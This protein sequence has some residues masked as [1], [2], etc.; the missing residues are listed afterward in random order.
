M[1]KITLNLMIEGGK[2]SSGPPLGPT[3]APLGV[4]ISEIVNSINASTKEFKGM[5][6]PVVVTVDPATKKYDIEIKTPATSQLIKKAI[7]IDKGRKEKGTIAGNLT[8]EQAVEIAKTKSQI[9]LGLTLKSVVK[10]VVGTCTSLG[11][12]VEKKS[13]MDVIK[14]I[15]KGIYDEKIK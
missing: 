9:S 11:V 12:T 3:L 13:P 6:I 8:I 15:D 5:T 10:E 7:G 14:E 4:N 1:D 2:A